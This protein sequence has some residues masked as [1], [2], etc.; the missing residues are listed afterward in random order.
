VAKQAA[1]NVVSWNKRRTSAAAA[2]AQS[3]AYG[4]VEAV[5]L[6]KNDF[7]AAFLA[8]RCDAD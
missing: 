8:L 6:S 7:S 5:P 1:Y 4:T 2:A 3:N